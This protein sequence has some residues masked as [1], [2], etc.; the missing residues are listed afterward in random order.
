[1][2]KGYGNAIVAPLAAE[3]VRAAIDAIIDSG[4]GAAD[5]DTGV[6]PQVDLE[7]VGG[8]T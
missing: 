8:P 2:L 3:F 5:V 7:P 1:M 6:T 4:Y